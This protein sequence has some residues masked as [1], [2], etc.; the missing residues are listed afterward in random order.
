[1]SQVTV[2]NTIAAH[3]PIAVHDKAS[4]LVE[5]LP[6]LEKFKNSIMVIKFGGN[7]MVDDDLIAAFADD[8][9][10]LKLCGIH[11]VVVHGGGPQISAELK[12]RGIEP[13]FA[14]GFRVTTP[15]VMTVVRDVLVD[16]VQSELVSHINTHRD[17]ARG[18]SG[19]VGNLLIAQRRD[20]DVDGVPTNIGLVG[21]VIE[22]NSQAITTA[23]AD[24]FIPVIS[25]V[26]LDPQ[27]QLLNV[28]ADTAAAAI[29]V[30][31]H[32]AKFVV[33][34]DIAGLYRNWP[35]TSDLIDVITVADLR[36]LVP[37]LESGMVPK[38]QAC[39]AAVD[40][41]LPQATVVDGRVAH[42]VLLEVFTSVGI[43]TMVVP[44]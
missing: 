12:A 16:Q 25:T 18:F 2:E 43:G 13:Q 6:W 30:A 29:A 8:V 22:V 40:G 17:V 9:V 39:I 33:L 19:D 28:N 4:I 35:D 34:T 26:A 44:S 11:P 27:G 10:F 7:A 42:C 3:S 24:G 14:G 20:V 21:E 37:N 38:M 23:I 1:M 31:L 5:A 15:E 36:T 41:G 32:A